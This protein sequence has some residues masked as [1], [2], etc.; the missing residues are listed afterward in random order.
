MIEGGVAG[1]T[2]GVR[3]CDMGVLPGNRVMDQTT[4]VQGVSYI[5]AWEGAGV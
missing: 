1:S 5:L 2:L 3:G 4:V